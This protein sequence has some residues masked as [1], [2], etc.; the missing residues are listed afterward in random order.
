M[1]MGNNLAQGL[2]FQT[3]LWML[4]LA[5]LGDLFFRDTFA[6]KNL[7]FFSAFIGLSG[8]QY[9]AFP[10]PLGAGNV[11]F[12]GALILLVHFWLRGGMMRYITAVVMFGFLPL[13]QDRKSTR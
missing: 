5:I 4:L 10:N 11:L 3:I 7:A 1:D 12:T 8:P 13:L 9:Q 2:L 6:L